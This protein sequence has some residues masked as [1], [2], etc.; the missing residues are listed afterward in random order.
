VSSHLTLITTLIAVVGRMKS[1]PSM[2]IR[3]TCERSHIDRV[4]IRGRYTK[5]R[6]WRL[7]I[8]LRLCGAQGLTLPRPVR[9]IS[10]GTNLTTCQ[11]A[12]SFRS[13]HRP[14]QPRICSGLRTTMGV[15]VLAF[16]CP[17]AATVVTGFS[18]SRSDRIFSAS[19]RKKGFQKQPTGFSPHRPTSVLSILL[20]SPAEPRAPRSR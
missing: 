4:M 19:I 16:P 5:L 15:T 18:L 11:Q 13:L 8:V 7:G 12:A 1:A 14:Q 20:V 9:R 10:E 6:V 3:M 17:R 2:D